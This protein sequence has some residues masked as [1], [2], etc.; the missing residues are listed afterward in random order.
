MPAPGGDPRPGS[1]R[2]LLWGAQLEKPGS[3]QSS[4]ELRRAAGPS[5][6]EAAPAAACANQRPLLWF[7]SGSYPVGSG[8]TP[9]SCHSWQARGPHVVQGT[10]PRS[11]TCNASAQPAVLT[12]RPGP[13]RRQT[14]G[15]MSLPLAAAGRGQVP[16]TRLAR[17]QAPSLS[18][19]YVSPKNRQGSLQAEPGTAPEH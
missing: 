10:E 12:L 7:G 14:T 9:G 13:D 11:A 1:T 8:L 2:K 5:L 18:T 16:R 17:S 4:G 15:F 6:A 19:R 3:G